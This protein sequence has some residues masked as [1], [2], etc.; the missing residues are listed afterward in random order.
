MT[1]VYLV[2]DRKTSAARLIRAANQAQAMR[3]AASDT[4]DISVATQ[5]DLIELLHMDIDVEEA[6]QGELQYIL[7]RDEGQHAD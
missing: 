6:N 7:D 3:H 4:F 5:N 1:R 2:T